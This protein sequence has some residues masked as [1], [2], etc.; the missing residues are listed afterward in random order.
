MFDPFDVHRG[1]NAGGGQTYFANRGGEPWIC[2]C[3]LGGDDLECN[4][5]TSNSIPPRPSLTRALLLAALVAGPALPV[6]AAD[7]D[8]FVDLF[9]G[10]DLDGWW[11]AATEDPRGYLD[12]S[13]EAFQ[14]KMR[15]SLEDI[16]QH[17]SAQDGV[18]VNDGHGLFLTTAEF[19][20]DFELLLEYVAA[21][22][23]DSGVYL[24]GCPQVQIW[25]KPEGSGGLWNNS[26]GAPGKEPL[27]LA[28][29]PAGEWNRFRLVMVGSRVWVWLNDQATVQGAVLENYFDRGSPVPARG[30]IQL[31][32]HGSEMRWRNVR[33]RPIDSEEGIR[34]LRGQDPDGFR[35]L[36]KG[37]TLSGWAGPLD[38][39]EF[40]DGVLQCRPGKGGT[41]YTEEEF[42]D[43]VVRL[44][45]KLPPGGNNG[46]AIRY[47]GK[48][49]TAYVGLCE[50]Q[51]LAEDFEQVKNHTLD[52]RQSHGSAYGMAAAR[53]GHQRPVG[54]WNYQEVTVQGSTLKVELNGTVI[55]DTDLDR[56]TEFMADKPH[57]GRNRR[58]G[59][60][61][62][63]GH[64]DPVQ[65]RNVSIH[66]MD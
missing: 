53:R 9:N 14:E 21:P 55:L 54:E 38:S 28:D 46:L 26:P 22:G 19:F 58:S 44:E 2:R 61:G 7:A 6:P 5:M 33:L 4:P 56:V 30:P 35:P 24:R 8:G 36:L 11:G 17:W 29:K 10:T 57:P 13:P 31:Q 41:L 50:L 32:T 64:N 3:I 51:V 1:L 23:A 49:D 63:A 25:E 18:L 47:P 20:G 40:K 15:K 62:F 16:R 45:F 12:L 34:W 66:P 60:F 37:D 39:Y 43:F 48:G 59:H 52:P 65:F 27:V 42:S